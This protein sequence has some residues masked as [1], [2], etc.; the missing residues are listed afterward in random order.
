MFSA[1]LKAV[2][3]LVDLAE[4]NVLIFMVSFDLRILYGMFEPSKPR[5]YSFFHP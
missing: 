4:F 5:V 1:F 2:D 3:L